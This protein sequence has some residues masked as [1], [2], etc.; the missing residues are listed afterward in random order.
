MTDLSPTVYY[1]G[2]KEHGF[3]YIFENKL[4]SAHLIKRKVFLLHIINLWHLA[5]N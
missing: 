3:N 4:K 5:I 1:F 2:V